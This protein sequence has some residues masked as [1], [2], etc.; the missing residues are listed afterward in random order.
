MIYL[1]MVV[2]IKENV[3]VGSKAPH[4]NRPLI[5]GVALVNTGISLFANKLAKTNVKTR[6]FFSK[7][8]K[9]I[10]IVSSKAPHINRPLIIGVALV[11]TGISLENISIMSQ[12]M[13]LSRHLLCFCCMLFVVF[14]CYIGTSR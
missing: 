8:L 7:K 12:S 4:I 5:I 9:I 3:I 11:N 1:G 14:C 6:Q 10:I 13:S 2:L